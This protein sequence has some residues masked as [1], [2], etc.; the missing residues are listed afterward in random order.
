MGEA[1]M[2]FRSTNNTPTYMSR[3]FQLRMIMMVVSL[4]VVIFA[5]KVTSRPSFL[6]GDVSRRSFGRAI[7][8]IESV[9]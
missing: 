7:R 2:R 9:C 4:G 8:E 5:I 3:P 6:G 1:S